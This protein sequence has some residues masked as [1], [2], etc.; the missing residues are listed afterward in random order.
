MEAWEQVQLRDSSIEL[1][2]R[3]LYRSWARE[4]SWARGSDM[5]LIALPDR[6]T[7]EQRLLVSRAKEHFE[8][9]LLHGSSEDGVP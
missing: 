6:L 5:L 2:R 3:L 1:L 8:G 4:S 9:A 7:P